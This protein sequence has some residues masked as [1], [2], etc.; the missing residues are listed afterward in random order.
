MRLV[1]FFS[2]RIELFHRCCFIEDAIAKREEA[3]DYIVPQPHAL[4]GALLR[5]YDGTFPELNTT[6]LEGTAV[7]SPL[8]SPWKQRHRRLRPKHHEVTINF[9]SDHLIRFRLMCFLWKVK[10]ELHDV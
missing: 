6:L 4:P 8:P 3:L 7:H 2:G 1:R 9:V 5:C 10:V